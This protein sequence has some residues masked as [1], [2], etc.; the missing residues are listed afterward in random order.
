MSIHYSAATGGFY[1]SEIHGDSIPKDAVEITPAQHAALL[2]GQSKGKQ[3]VAD[4]DGKPALQ[5]PPAATPEELE[6]RTTAARAAAYAKEADPLF[7]KSQRGEA[8]REEW[9]AKVQEIKDR[10][11]KP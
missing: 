7:L 10:Y 9:L 8:T 2:D 3:I 11:P 6:A 4:K 5:D 1:D